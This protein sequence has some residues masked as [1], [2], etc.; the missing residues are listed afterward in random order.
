VADLL[1]TL[2][3]HAGALPLEIQ[4]EMLGS[5]FDDDRARAELLERV[6]REGDPSTDR[7]FRLPG[8]RFV[9]ATVSRFVVDLNRAPDDR[10]PNGV[11]KASDFSGRPLYP[12]GGAPDEEAILARLRRYHAPFHAQVEHEIARRRPW[13]I[14]DGHSMTAA[15]PSLGPDRGRPRPAV[16]LITG[17]GPDGEPTDRPVSLA[18]E[19]ARRLAAA[20]EAALTARLPLG[21]HGLPAGVR[22]N[23]PFAHGFVQ[24]RYGADPAGPRVP[25]VSIE[26]HRGLFEDD[27]ARPRADRVALLRA[28]VAEAVAT[29]RPALREA[30]A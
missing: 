13:L 17:G 24:E 5:R 3:H 10:G 21:S 29:L 15:G 25:T 30:T 18:P 16:S 4:A 12:P 27:E 11:V 8:A 9:S 20:L 23:D 28:A 14:V 26:L 22:I 7:L 1:V 2:P 6:R 19:L